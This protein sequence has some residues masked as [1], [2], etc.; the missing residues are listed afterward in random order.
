[1]KTV[2]HSKPF[3]CKIQ[4]KKQ[5]KEKSMVLVGRLSMQKHHIERQKI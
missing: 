1:M 2:S 4:M 3:D 5:Q